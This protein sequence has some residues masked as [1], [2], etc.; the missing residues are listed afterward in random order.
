MNS[1]ASVALLP[2]GVLAV[3]AVALLLMIAVRRNHRSTFLVSLGGFAASFALLFI[4]SSSVSIPPLLVVDHFSRFFTGLIV[5]ANLTVCVLSYE[6]FKKYAGNKDEFYL[7]LLLET[8]GGSIL[9]ASSH[10]VSL[11][12]GFEILGVS[13]YGLIAYHRERQFSIEAGIKYLILAAVSSTFILFGMALIYAQYGTLTIAEAFAPLAGGGGL[14]PLAIAGLGLMIVG[15]GFKLAF[16]PFHLWAADVY[17]G[18]PAPVTTSIATV[19]K[20]SV[21]ALLLRILRGA[22]ITADPSLYWVFAL[23]AA[24]SMLAGNWLGLM[25]NN[26]KRMLAYSSIAHFGYLLIPIIAGGPQGTAV[27]CFYLVAYTLASLGS[28][29]VVTV[30]S[31]PDGEAEE[32]GNYAGLA[33]R[34]PLLGGVFIIMLV[35][36]AGVPL[37]A[38]FLAKLYVFTTGVGSSLWFLTIVLVLGSSIG[39]YYYLRL[40]GIQLGQPEGAEPQRAAPH[41]RA[42][43]SI[44]A[45]LQ[46]FLGL[47]PQPL[48]KLIE[49]LLPAAR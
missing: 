3:S 44:L 14:R 38:G 17:Q 35:S 47:F 19:S 12:L 13:L 26:V 6:Y 24:G 9:V 1:A 33:W 29:G 18:S 23:V 31:E 36:L 39:L 4:D 5:L 25:Q 43:L 11:F 30:M 27:A 49:T 42:V 16:V 2:L 45:F 7:L 34:S 32:S 15:I 20:V 41:A 21:F 8:M 46:L 48:L 10:F 40:V 37:T 22:D 28:F